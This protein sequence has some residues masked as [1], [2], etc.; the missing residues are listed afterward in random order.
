MRRLLLLLALGL[1]LLPRPAARASERAELDD[2]FD[3]W[4]ADL[5]GLGSAPTL[6]TYVVD[7]TV[8][9]EG[10][11]RP[12]LSLHIARTARG[13][14]RI[15][16]AQAGSG[17]VVQAFDGRVAWQSQVGGGL[18][19]SG[20]PSAD[21]WVLQNDILF[22]V[23]AFRPGI[24]HSQEASVTLRGH[25]CLVARVRDSQ[26][27]TGRCWIDRSTHELLRIERDL[28]P[29]ST[30]TIDYDDFRRVDHL[31]IPF[32]ARVQDG[33]ATGVIHRRSSVVLDAPVDE[34]SMVL[35][36][37]DLNEALALG[38]ILRRHD[39]TV[40]SAEALASLHTRVAHLTLELSTVGTTSTQTIYQKAPDRILVE[41]DTPGMG[42]ETRGFDGTTAWTESLLQGYR[43]LKPAEAAQLGAEGSLHVVG[44]LADNFP[45]RLRVGERVIN[46]R[47][48]DA[49]SLSSLQGKAGTFYFDRQNGR[50]LRI[51]SPVAGDRENSTEATVDYADFRDVGGI[52]VPYVLTQTNPL[53]RA[54]STILSIDVNP[55]LQ[56]DLFRPRRD[57]D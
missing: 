47:P 38:A 33:R 8:E 45:F 46:G 44:R 49:I 6:R 21:P 53:M 9:F 27:S 34:A 16:L 22:P 36:T 41:T 11:S 26:G 2:F 4:V 28:A 23:R 25:A 29:R 1:G 10:V 52:E 43:P 14:F 3:R 19:V 51:G 5:A 35:S 37:A 56:D 50:L 42:R 55:P 57:D 7:E 20:N 17:L 48:T 54:V 30:M 24:E 31:R 13:L 12:K 39:A 15:E 32:Y 18:G 40:G